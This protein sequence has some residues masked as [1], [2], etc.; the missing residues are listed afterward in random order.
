MARQPESKVAIR[1]PRVVSIVDCGRVIAPRTSESQVRGGVVWGIGSA[2]REESE[3]DPRYGG[4]LN[5]DIADYVMPVNAD[6]GE[7]DVG[8]IDKTGNACSLLFPIVQDCLM[9]PKR[10]QGL[11][12]SKPP[13]NGVSEFFRVFCRIHGIA[14]LASSQCESSTRLLVC[15]SKIWAASTDC[16]GPDGCRLVGDA[17]ECD[18]RGNTLGDLCPAQSEGKVRC[19]PDGGVNILRCKKGVL[20]LEFVCPQT[21]VC[22]FIEDAGLTCR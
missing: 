11:S 8:F 1:V 18:L 3:V 7:I 16:K 13:V 5:N 10:Q 4:W 12:F 15:Q 14:V 17:Y 21:T 9:F 22:Q 2:L 6:I 19:D 20:N